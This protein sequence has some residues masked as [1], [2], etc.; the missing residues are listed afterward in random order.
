MRIL[1]IAA[2]LTALA[3][4]LALH[5]AEPAKKDSAKVPAPAAKTQ[6][7]PEQEKA[8]VERGVKILSLFHG[9]LQNKEIPEDQKGYLFSC[10]YKNNLEKVSLATGEIL[11]KNPKLDGNDPKTLY[12]AAATVCGVTKAPSFAK[13]HQ[14][15]APGSAAQVKG[16]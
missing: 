4:P 9:A 11:S 2:T 15:A 10:L 14:P 6:F 13:A 12:Q 8:N 16:R 5:A 1:S 7:T 3:A